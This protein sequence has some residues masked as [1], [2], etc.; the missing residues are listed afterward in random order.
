[1]EEEGLAL[2]G[3][4]GFEFLELILPLEDRFE[5]DDPLRADPLQ[6]GDLLADDIDLLGC[7]QEVGLG[8]DK[9]LVGQSDLEEGLVRGDGFP[10][11]REDL[12]HRSGDRRDDRELRSSAAFD[13]DPR[14]A[15]GQVEGRKRDIPFP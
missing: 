1:M 8:L 9:L 2:G 13:H 12:G 4:D 5:R 10:F 14:H 6:P 3:T 11:G 15:D 7:F